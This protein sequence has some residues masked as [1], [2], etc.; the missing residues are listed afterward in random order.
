MEREPIGLRDRDGREI[1]EGDI[2]EFTVEY[3]FGRNPAPSYD[4]E[5]GTRMVDTVKLV[6][7]VP[8]FWD[9]DLNTGSL[10]N[11]HAKHCRVIGN[12]HDAAKFNGT[13][14]APRTET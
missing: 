13:E 10:A 2:V 11:R 6:E 8:C 1:C 7:G 12:I 9:E 14:E 5:S 4:T 3:G